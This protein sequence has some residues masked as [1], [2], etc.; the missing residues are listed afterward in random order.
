MNFNKVKLFDG[1]MGTM[2]QKEGLKLGQ[3]PEDMN[4]THEKTIQKIHKGYFES[5]ADYIT[6]NTFGANSYK[7]KKS[8]YN[9]EDIVTKAINNAKRACPDAEVVLDIGPIGKALKPIG[10]LSFDKAYEMFK[11]QILAAKNEVNIVLIETM[12]SLLEAKAAILAAKEN[13]NLK[14][15]VTMTIDEQLRTLDGSDVKC[16]AI[17]LSNLNVDCIGL[18]CSLGPKQLK[19]P[20]KELV[21]YSKVDV[22]IQ[23]NAGLPIIK[24]SKTIYDYPVDKFKNDLKEIL[25]YG[26][27]IIG[28]C[29]GTTYKYIEALNDLK[30]KNIIKVNKIESSFV[31]SGSKVV[32]IGDKKVIIGERIN[33]TGKERLK[34][35]IIKKDYD[36]ILKEVIKQVDAGADILDINIGLPKINEKEVYKEIIPE[37]Q[38]ITNCPLQ[39]DTVDIKA[40]DQACRVYNGRPI[41][42]SVNA[43]KESLKKILPIAKKYGALIIG[44]TLDENGLPNGRNERI[45]L[46]KKIIKNAKKHQI[47]E[48]DILIDCVTLSVSTH[49]DQVYDILDAIKYLKEN[50]NVKTTLGASNISF[51]LPFRDLINQTFLI[52]AFTK[53]LDTAIT[54]PTN[55]MIRKAIMSFKLLNGSQN[56][57]ENYVE[58]YSENKKKNKTIDKEIKDLKEIVIKGFKGDAKKATKVLLE[59][60][61]PLDIVNKYLITALDIVGKDYEDQKIFLP[62]LIR[63]AETVKASFEVLKSSMDMKTQYTKGK[64][65][66]ATVKGDIHDIGK[67]IVKILLENYGFDVIDLGKDVSKEKIVQKIKKQNIKVVGL[68]ALMTTTVESM[69]ETIKFIHKNNLDCKIVVGG[70]ILN[71]EYAEYVNADYYAKDAKATVEFCNEILNKN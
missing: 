13:S 32:E 11:Q 14:V 24:D 6:T 37:I 16:I 62:Q 15:F 19:K 40:L 44:L 29:C 22:M 63:S 56:D 35:A 12:S 17:T 50:F 36:Y 9:V 20:I 26:V 33:P 57:L 4:F 2:L 66:L 41:I 67:N 47:N 53:G 25:D 27:S 42:N 61:K 60:N 39:I 34:D 58:N 65:I 71:E 5:G 70:A 18:N 30:G 31:T 1:A 54:D 48:R 23:P 46:A 8:K 7:L 51:G 21:K 43:K 45:N 3:C 69:K 59:K 68:S 10:D 28:G 49:Q 64:V 55:E 52:M 38:S